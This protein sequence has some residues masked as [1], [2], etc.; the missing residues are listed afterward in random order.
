GEQIAFNSNLGTTYRGGEINQLG[1]SLKN[2]GEG[3]SLKMVAGQAPSLERTWILKNSKRGTQK[4][5]SMGSLIGG[6]SSKI[7]SSDV[8]QTRSSSLL[9]GSLSALGQSI[10]Y[11]IEAKRE[12]DT[13]PSITITSPQITP[14]LPAITPSPSPE[15]I[16]SPTT[17]VAPAQGGITLTPPGQPAP[18][19]PGPGGISLPTPGIPQ[20][21]QIIWKQYSLSQAFGRNPLIIGYLEYPSTWL[22]N[23]D[24]FN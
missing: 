21:P 14:A 11:E 22:V 12:A 19:Q 23:L 3:I 20:E 10:T 24:S 16:V 7:G 18:A 15:G 8:D 5:V 2:L 17:P 9:G 1:S 13:L 6:I 4:D